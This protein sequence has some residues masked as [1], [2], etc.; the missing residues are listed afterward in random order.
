MVVSRGDRP[1]RVGWSAGTRRRH[2]TTPVVTETSAG[3]LVG[4]LVGEVVG[5]VVLVRHGETAWSRSG[6]HT[7]FSD[8]ELTPAGEDEARAAAVKLADRR[9]AAVFTS[10]MRRARGDV[11]ARGLRRSR[12]R[13]RRPVRVE[14]RRLR[15][16]HHGADPGDEPRLDHLHRRPAGWGDVR[17]GR[18]RADAVI[19]RAVAAEARSGDVARSRTG[20]SCVCSAA[21]DRP[22]RREGAGLRLDT[23]TSASSATSTTVGCCTSGTPSVIRVPTMRGNTATRLIAAGGHEQVLFVGDG[24]VGLRAI[25]AVHSTAL[26]PSLGGVRFWH[27]DDD[28]SALR[29]ALRLSEAMTL[30]AALAGLH[31]GGGKAVVLWDDPGRP[32]R[33]SCSTRSGARLTVSAVAT[34]QRRTSARRPPTW[35]GWPRSRRG[36]P[37]SVSRS[38]VRATRRR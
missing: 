36:S 26:G 4:E 24:D 17:A 6:Q 31:Q 11:R 21:V 2:G 37:G 33:R 38:V 8:V 5:E 28:E 1:F 14:L 16:P 22:R 35:T 32:A 30:K 19:K 25:I 29:V 20:T 7:S 10:P 34:S 27:Y 3:E 15:G 12:S 18:C 13:H 9:F 23:A